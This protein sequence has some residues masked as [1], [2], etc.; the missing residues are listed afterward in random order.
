M[1]YKKYEVLVRKN[2]T[3]DIDFVIK[4][5]KKS[6]NKKQDSDPDTLWTAEIFDLR[7][8]EKY[9]IFSDK[10]AKVFQI[11]ADNYRTRDGTVIPAVMYLG[12]SFNNDL[13]EELKKEI[14][15][16]IKGE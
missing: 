14:L 13:K 1:G 6:I 12:K 4:L 3:A 8:L 5:F 2:S 11:T 16:E 10:S 15:N 7:T 9:L